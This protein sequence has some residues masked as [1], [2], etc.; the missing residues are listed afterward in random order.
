MLQKYGISNRENLSFAVNIAIQVNVLP[1]ILRR[2][3][4]TKDKFV[5]NV[6]HAGSFL[7]CEKIVKKPAALMN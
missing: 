7:Q 4:V 2:Y 5:F 3:I 6:I 1:L